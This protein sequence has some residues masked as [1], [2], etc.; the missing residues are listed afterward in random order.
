MNFALKMD[1]SRNTELCTTL[2]TN[3]S[4][5]RQEKSNPEPSTTPKPQTHNTTWLF[6]RSLILGR[7]LNQGQESLLDG[8]LFEGTLPGNKPR[9]CL[10][11][12]CF[13]TKKCS[14]EGFTHSDE[15][16][17]WDMLQALDSNALLSGK[18]GS[19]GVCI[20]YT[21]SEQYHSVEWVTHY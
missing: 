12:L 17:Y 1:S 15:I 19:K 11:W 5:G 16:K 10:V 3:I 14:P 2:N 20:Y 7:T 6:Q 13:P 21:C 8:S 9:Q 18:T 4:T